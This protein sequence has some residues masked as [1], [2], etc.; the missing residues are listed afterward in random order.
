MGCVVIIY[1]IIVHHTAHTLHTLHTNPTTHTHTLRN[2]QTVTD[3][4]VKSFE[5]DRRG[6]IGKRVEIVDFRYSSSEC[7]FDQFKDIFV[8][9][10]RLEDQTEG[11]RRRGE[12][13]VTQ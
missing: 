5:S 1:I 6:I 12:R 4:Q 7:V 13:Y 3:G 9:I 2:C 8:Q 10:L 11:Q